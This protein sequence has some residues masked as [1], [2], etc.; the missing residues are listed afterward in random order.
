MN[1]VANYGAG[2][3]HV[4]KPSTLRFHHVLACSGR[5]VTGACPTEQAVT[6][7]ACAKKLA[8]DTLD[9]KTYEKCAGLPGFR[10]V[11]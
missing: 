8:A 10:E 4:A 6:C 11:A 5:A 2:K 3:V 9:G 1:I 7:G